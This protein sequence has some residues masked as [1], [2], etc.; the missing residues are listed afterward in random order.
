[1]NRKLK[2]YTQKKRVSYTCGMR[3]IRLVNVC[4]YIFF[5]FYISSTLN[6]IVF[7]TFFNLKEKELSMS[8]CLLKYYLMQARFIFHYYFNNH[9]V[10]VGLL[11][12]NKINLAPS[13]PRGPVH[14]Y[15]SAQ[16]ENILM[17]F[18]ILKLYIKYKF[19]IGKYII[20][21][22]NKKN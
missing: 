19:I 20:S 7:I 1:M 11:N 13:T 21:E 12:F 4:V 5:F 17:N 18:Y 15:I 22:S 3:A 9:V 16:E 10:N 2:D 14:L 8:G 6:H